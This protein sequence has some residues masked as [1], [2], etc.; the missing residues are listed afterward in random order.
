MTQYLQPG[1]FTLPTCTASIDTVTYEIRVGLRC[2]LCYQKFTDSQQ[3][4]EGPKHIC[5]TD[6]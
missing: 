6:C 4:G 5:H 3:S 2:P 1:P